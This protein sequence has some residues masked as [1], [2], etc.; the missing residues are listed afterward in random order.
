MCL[1]STGKSLEK[2]KMNHNIGLVSLRRSRLAVLGT[3]I[4][5]L[6]GLPWGRA[7]DSGSVGFIDVSRYDKRLQAHIADQGWVDYQGLSRERRALDEFLEE[8]AKASP[9]KYPRNQEKLAFWINAYNAFTLADA[10][11]SVYGH[12][13]SVRQVSGFFDGKKHPV[14][15]QQL[16]LDEVEQRGSSKLWETVRKIQD[17]LKRSMSREPGR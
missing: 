3:A 9:A 12:H 1:K 10:L 13:Q 4:L 8:L 16:T 6:M 17:G 5:I 2:R 11:D 15:G 7:A 14:G